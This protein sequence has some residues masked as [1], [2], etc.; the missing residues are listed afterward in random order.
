[1]TIVIVAKGFLKLLNLLVLIKQKSLAFS[2]NL[3]LA[4]S[5]ELLTMFSTKVN[6][7]YLLYLANLRCCLLLLIKRNC[8]QN[9]FFLEL[10][11]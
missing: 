2:R 11:S 9:F 6:L 10:E 1:M 7:L 4:T 8:S 3:V 5:G